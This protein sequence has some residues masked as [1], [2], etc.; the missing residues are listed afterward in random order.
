MFKHLLFLAFIIFFSNNNVLAETE[1]NPR[2]D[3]QNL[4]CVR[5]C[6]NS[7]ESQFAETNIRSK[8]D[9]A[10]FFARIKEEFN[11]TRW[12]SECSHAAHLL[13]CIQQCST[14]TPTLEQVLLAGMQIHHDFCSDYEVMIPSVVCMTHVANK[15]KCKPS[16]EK[17][18]GIIK[19]DS[20]R[21][22]AD[23]LCEAFVCANNCAM[24]V[25]RKVCGNF[26]AKMTHDLLRF[27]YT[28]SSFSRNTISYEDCSGLFKAMS[29][30]NSTNLS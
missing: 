11:K 19:I 15:V 10:L 27:V 25:M 7:T 9:V 13:N 29:T 26:V 28:L 8:R 3:V 12:E 16:C 2:E 30:I 23:L 20:T 14:L 5:Q 18:F 4:T 24:G 1:V 6:L 22:S 17:E 21:E